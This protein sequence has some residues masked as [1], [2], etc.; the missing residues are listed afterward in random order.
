MNIIT[1]LLFHTRVCTMVSTDTRTS[2]SGNDSDRLLRL[3]VVIAVASMV[4]IILLSAYSFYRI[5]TGFVI[6]SAERDSVR[7]CNLL[8]DEHKS[9][10]FSDASEI[11]VHETDIPELDH[12][13]SQIVTNSCLQP[14]MVLISQEMLNHD[15]VLANPFLL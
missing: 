4:V 2:Q 12:N 11:A 6:T 7:L 8:I 1:T 15:S 10:M 13:V 9:L 14:I 3:L 5:F